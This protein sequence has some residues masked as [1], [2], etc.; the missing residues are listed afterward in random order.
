MPAGSRLADAIAAAGGAEADAD[1]HR[2]NLAA[3]AVD[4][5]HI[6]VPGPDDTGEA[7]GLPLIEY[8]SSSVG[9]AGAPSGPSG[10]GDTRVNVNRADG[11]ALESL[12][13]IG[14]ATAA[15]ILSWREENGPF[16]TVDD[17]LQVPGIGPAKLAAIEDRVEL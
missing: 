11:T 7:G 17:L 5:M 15:A 3:P 10:L 9:G 2:L 6:R 8:G 16:T 12:P 4:G 14:P 13:G 1:V